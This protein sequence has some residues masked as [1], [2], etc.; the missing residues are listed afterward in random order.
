MSGPLFINSAVIRA[1]ERL[2]LRGGRWTFIDIAVR[3]GLWGRPQLGAVLIDTGYTKRITEGR[4]RSLAMKLYNAV[5]RPRLIEEASPIATLRSHG[6][7]PEDVTYI[8]VT[9]FHADHIAAL[10]DFP[11][12]RFLADG[13]A[14]ARLSAM[15]YRQQ[16]HNGFFPDLLP[17]DFRNRLISVDSRP[18]V[19]LPY[20][21]GDGY[22]LFADGSCLAV[23]LPGHAL[24]HFGLLWPNMSPALLYATD[25]QWLLRAV[26]E[27]RAPSGPARLIYSD[28][29]AA[30]R[31]MEKVR[32]FAAQGGRVMLCHEPSN[33][34]AFGGER[35]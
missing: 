7:G 6:I 27:E 21:L 13:A 32:R 20:D 29:D 8:V 9:H 10:C 34:T 25:T 2:V 19:A 17:A 31:S 14:Y 35:S 15:T 22:D 16:L 3:Y 30:A 5:L 33:P 26:N 1:P 28:R 23:P 11:R 12:A 18:S 24:G 4:E